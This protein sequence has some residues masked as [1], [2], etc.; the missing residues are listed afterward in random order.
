VKFIGSDVETPAAGLSYELGSPAQHGTATVNPDGTWTYTP[1]TNYNGPDTFTYTIEDA[2]GAVSDPVT[3]TVTVTPVNDAPVGTTGLS[4]TGNEGGVVTGTL[5]GTDVDSADL[6]F[7]VRGKPAHGTVTVNPTRSVSYPPPKTST[8]RHLHLH[9][10]DEHLIS[11]PATSPSRQPDQRRT[12]R[13]HTTSSQSKTHTVDLTGTDMTATPQLQ[14][15]YRAHTAR[16]PR[17]DGTWTTPPAT[18]T[19]HRPFTYTSRR[20]ATRSSPSHHLTPRQ[21]RPHRRHR[22]DLFSNED[23][24]S[25]DSPETT[26][27]ATPSHNWPQAQKRHRHHQPHHGADLHPRR[28]FNARHLTFTVSDGHLISTPPRHHTVPNQR[29]TTEPTPPSPQSTTTTGAPISGTDIDGDTS[30]TASVPSRTRHVNIAPDGTLPTPRQQLH[31]TTPSPTPSRGTATTES[32]HVTITV[33]PFNDPPPAPI[34]P[35]GDED[36]STIGGSLVGDERRG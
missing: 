23:T 25:R 35:Y 16:Q 19:P 36:S 32:H 26:S 10:L 1:A 11:T 15:R 5:A 12:H 24:T 8:H 13:N 21:R 33:T 27:T 18:I 34:P 4:G 6:T 20:T 30:A 14:H 29:R 7:A 3:V 2:D 22:P 31:R 9:R 28:N 17:P